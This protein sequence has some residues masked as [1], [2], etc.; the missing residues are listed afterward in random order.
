MNT[1]VF[2]LL[3]LHLQRLFLFLKLTLLMI[4]AVI[5]CCIFNLSW[6]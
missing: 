1:P 5:W 4:T 2:V 6:A 3:R